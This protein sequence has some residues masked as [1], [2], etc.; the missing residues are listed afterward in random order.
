MGGKTTFFLAL[1]L[2]TLVAAPLAAAAPAPEPAQ[3]DAPLCGPYLGV[4]CAA[5]GEFCQ[6][7]IGFSVRW[8]IHL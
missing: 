1:V 8:C 4:R 3:A 5:G 6:V 7:W 2:T